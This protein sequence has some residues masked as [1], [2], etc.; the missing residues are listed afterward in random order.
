[1]NVKIDTK[2]IFYVISIMDTEL[3]ANMSATLLALI[4]KKQ[5]DETKSVI[6][7]FEK[8]Q[9]M[10]K[11]FASVLNNLKENLYTKNKSFV[12][13]NLSEN[14]KQNLS[15]WGILE[16]LNHTPTE[17]EAW[18]IVQMEEIERELDADFPE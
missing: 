6:L 9:Q 1:M 16:S 7:N 5:E 2:E 4:A 12:I 18:D 3:T 11:D 17:S 8:V 15:N 14:V 13:C 10:D